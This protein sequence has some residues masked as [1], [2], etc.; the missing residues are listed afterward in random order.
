M[1]KTSL[2]TSASFWKKEDITLEKV[3]ENRTHQQDYPQPS[4]PFPCLLVPV[5]QQGGRSGCV[6]VSEP[7]TQQPELAANKIASFKCLNR[8]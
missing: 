3:K 4:L 6:M 8:L 5:L 7:M 2:S 1:Y